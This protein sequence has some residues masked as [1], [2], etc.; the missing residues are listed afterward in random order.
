MVSP[1]RK[2]P[3]NG[4]VNWESKT[5]T[6]LVVTLDDAKG[7]HIIQ[8]AERPRE[9]SV[10]FVVTSPG[11]ET[12]GASY[13]T[14]GP[15][16][17][18]CR[19]DIVN[20]SAIAWCHPDC[21]NWVV[22]ATYQGGGSP[23]NVA[24]I[25]GAALDGG[26][27]FEDTPRQH[28]ISG[29]FDWHS[30]AM[31]TLTVAPDPDITG[32]YSIQLSQ[33]PNGDT[34]AITDVTGAFDYTHIDSATP[35]ATE[36]AIGRRTGKIFFNA[37][38]NGN[39][40]KVHDGADGPWE[41]GGVVGNLSQI[42]AAAYAVVPVGSIMPWDDSITGVPA[43]PD[44]WQLCDGSEIT[45]AASPMFGEFTKDLNGDGRFL[46]GSATAGT[47]Q[48]HAFQLHQ[49]YD[50]T[51]AVGGAYV[52]ADRGDSGARNQTT[53]GYVADGGG[54]PKTASETRPINMSVKFIV[55]I[56]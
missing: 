37:S 10:S 16:R 9:D 50:G 40:I 6:G 1:S 8:L 14:T 34:I 19:V 15:T 24:S 44:R 51:R 18:E 56:K 2:N 27:P 4:A 43:L 46:R 22:N 29:V 53:A 55:R 41:G 11:G 21:L 33:I 13:S 28:P 54:T 47:L 38:Q 52:L 7:I 12:L 49:H 23:G 26:L 25:R 36:C 31:A 30:V 45:D 20:G 32:A 5:E 48:D 35:A 39:S 17:N 3:V 42:I